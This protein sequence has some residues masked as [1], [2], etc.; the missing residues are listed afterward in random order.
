MDTI[1]KSTKVAVTKNYKDINI[2]KLNNDIQVARE[3]M[4]KQQQVACIIMHEI[5]KLP[6][7]VLLYDLD[8]V[9]I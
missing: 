3:I 2:E 4:Q 7:F 5:F 6:I 8:F 9:Y 1:Q